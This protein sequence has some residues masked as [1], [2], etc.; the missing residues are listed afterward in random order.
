MNSEYNF[1]VILEY[2]LG[3]QIQVF[4]TCLF[5]GSF[6]KILLVECD[7]QY[8]NNEPFFCFAIVSVRPLVPISSDF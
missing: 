4:L 6:K 5:A 2:I 3:I 8:N 7:K 1:F